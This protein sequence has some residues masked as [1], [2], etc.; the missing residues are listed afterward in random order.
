[1]TNESTSNV[2]LLAHGPGTGNGRSCVNDRQ[3]YASLL[4]VK[5]ITGRLRGRFIYMSEAVVLHLDA[6]GF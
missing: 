3:N 5:V 2:W 4:R 6:A 1:M